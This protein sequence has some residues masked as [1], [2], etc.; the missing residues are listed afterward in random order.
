VARQAAA[1]GLAGWV[2]NCRDGSVEAV[3][4]G[5]AAAVEAMIAACRIG[6][7]AAAVIDVRVEDDAGSSPA[8][9]TVRPTM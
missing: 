2:R 9:F 3:F 8:S 4:A 5:E 1:R 6:P 7:P